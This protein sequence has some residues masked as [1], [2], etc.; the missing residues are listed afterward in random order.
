VLALL[1]PHS[2]AELQTVGGADG[3]GLAERRQ[4]CG[5]IRSRP[6]VGVP[7]QHILTIRDERGSRLL[8]AVTLAA[9]HAVTPVAVRRWSPHELAHA[10]G[11]RATLASR[12]NC[13]DLSGG[14]TLDPATERR[15]GSDLAS[16]AKNRWTDQVQVLM[17]ASRLPIPTSMLELI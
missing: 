15:V 1:E 2:R 10:C 5:R 8:F 4:W 12:G 9:S 6:E 13:S 3:G 11:T 16:A 14:G 7:G 17:F